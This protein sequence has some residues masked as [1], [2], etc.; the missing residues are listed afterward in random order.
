MP[1]RG[2]VKKWGRPVRGVVKKFRGHLCDN[3]KDPYHRKKC[4]RKY[5]KK[6]KKL[7]AIK[8]AK[9]ARMIARRAAKV[10]KKIGGGMKSLGQ[11]NFKVVNGVHPLNRHHKPCQ[12][13]P[14]AHW[15]DRPLK[16]PRRL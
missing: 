7:R 9:K 4:F 10:A 12:R 8:A 14:P 6:A 1:V 13:N 3:V 2:A 11:L 15:C 16:M 5:K